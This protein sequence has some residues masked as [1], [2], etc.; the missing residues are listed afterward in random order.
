MN[1]ISTCS[2]FGH[3]EIEIT[4]ELEGKLIAT[5]EDLIKQGCKY[6]YFGGF[7]EFDDL[8]H[9]VI[10]KLKITYPHIQRIFCLSDPRHQRI[11]KR[12]KWLKD[13]D[14]EEFIYLDLDFDWWYQR[15]YYR[16]CA[17]IDRSDIVVFY[18]EERENSGAYKAYKYAKQKKKTII[19]IL[20]PP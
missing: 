19:N 4:K 20:Q 7:S 8:C 14:Y 18:V 9:K 16:N 2:V 11:S 5:F 13:E 17:M 6:F 1:N 3:S 12:P 15:I 10:S